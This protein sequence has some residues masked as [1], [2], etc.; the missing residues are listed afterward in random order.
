MK[1]LI[2][3]LFLWSAGVMIF[4]VVIFTAYTVLQM[5]HANACHD[6]RGASFN[7]IRS[8]G[9]PQKTSNSISTGHF[10][11]FNNQRNDGFKDSVLDYSFYLSW[12][13]LAFQIWMWFKTLIFLDDLL[14]Q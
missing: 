9:T 13:T 3:C 2:N 8:G 5:N 7:S 6:V 10:F 4:A 12:V 14:P 1:L 11:P